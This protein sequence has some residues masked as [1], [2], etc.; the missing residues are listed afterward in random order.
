MLPPE[1]IR[2]G[3]AGKNF[4]KEKVYRYEIRSDAENVVSVFVAKAIDGGV[5][6]RSV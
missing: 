6:C 5:S 2:A 4:T 1:N 3:R